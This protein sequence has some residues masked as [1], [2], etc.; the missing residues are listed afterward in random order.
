MLALGDERIETGAGPIEV[1]AVVPQWD[2]D[3]ESS[4]EMRVEVGDVRV[5][6]VKEGT[7]GVEAQVDRQA[8]DEGLDKAPRSMRLPERSEMWQLPS[9]AASPLER[10]PEL[11]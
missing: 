4:M 3:D 2:V 7:L 5:D 11:T 8:A 9:F 10:R 1:G 6:V